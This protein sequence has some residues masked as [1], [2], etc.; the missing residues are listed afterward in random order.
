MTA[1]KLPLICLFLEKTSA[2]IRPWFFSTAKLPT[3]EVMN[4]HE[5][6]SGL[7]SVLGQGVFGIPVWEA[8]GVLFLHAWAML[9]VVNLLGTSVIF[10]LTDVFTRFAF[11]PFGKWLLTRKPIHTFLAVKGPAWI[12][13]QI[14][15]IQTHV[16]GARRNSS[17]WI[18]KNTPETVILALNA[19]PIPVFSELTTS[20]SRAFK[21]K[22]TWPCLLI[23]C[24]V[25]S[26]IACL[27][28]YFLLS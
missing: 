21:R 14:G 18:Q 28:G 19:L 15:H 9:A 26:F 12:L 24:L 20:A 11:I 16:N 25:R 27:I 13:Q 22:W 8:G 2:R 6:L 23:N 5:I 7:P 10:Y 1:A 3:I 17:D 4:M